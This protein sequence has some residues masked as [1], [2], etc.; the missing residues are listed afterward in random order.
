M[1]VAYLIFLSATYTV[2]S[3]SET[4]LFQEIVVVDIEQVRTAEHFFFPPGM[5]S[6]VIYH[7]TSKVHFY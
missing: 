4:F 5:A 7:F 1:F 6:G 2:C 3:L